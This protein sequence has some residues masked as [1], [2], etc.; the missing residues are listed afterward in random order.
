MFFLTLFCSVIMLL[1]ICSAGWRAKY[2]PEV[3]VG[4]VTFSVLAGLMF[5]SAG[6]S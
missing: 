4:C 5:F 2:L 6:A 1:A 3:F